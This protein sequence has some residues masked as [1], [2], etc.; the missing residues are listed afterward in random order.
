MCFRKIEMEY[1]LYLIIQNKCLLFYPTGS[2][3]AMLPQTPPLLKWP[4]SSP[5]P[6]AS[7]HKNKTSM[8]ALNTDPKYSTK[9]P[10]KKCAE[11][12]VLAMA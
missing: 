3:F 12:Q 1:R 10:P 2:K 4:S 7:S 5:K 11:P 9:L 8:V 6:P